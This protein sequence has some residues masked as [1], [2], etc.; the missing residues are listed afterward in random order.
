MNSKLDTTVVNKSVVS[1]FIYLFVMDLVRVPMESFNEYVAREPGYAEPMLKAF[2]NTFQAKP[3]GI[4]SHELLKKI[5]KTSTSHLPEAGRGEYKVCSNNFKIGPEFYTTGS[6][7]PLF[8]GTLLGLHELINT[9]IIN[10]KSHAISLRDIGD[11]TEGLKGW[12][13][14]P[15]SEGTAVWKEYCNG[16]LTAEQYI[17]KKH[18]PKLDEL[19]TDST[20]ETSIDPLVREDDTTV[21][22]K[23]IELM[24]WIIDDYEAEIV[25]CA[26]DDEKITSICKYIQRIEQLHPFAD[27]NVRTIYILLNK[28]LRDHGLTFSLLLNPNRFDA[29]DL[30]DLVR[31]VKE[32]QIIFKSLMENTNP[33]E[34]VVRTNERLGMLTTIRCPGVTLA[35]SGL[36]TQFIEEVLCK[37]KLAAPNH[38]FKTDKQGIFSMKAGSVLA[39]LIA[40]IKSVATENNKDILVALRKGQIGIAFRR[41]CIMH[42]TSSIGI[43]LKYKDKLNIDVNEPSS[44]TNTA[45]DWFDQTKVTTKAEKATREL[46]VEHGA[47]NRQ[48]L[49]FGTSS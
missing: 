47:K 24:Q 44:N 18:L 5:Q 45:L 26:T 17:P 46:L 35:C 21:H 32:G 27:G 4:I 34:F 9:W 6:I 3:D 43:F 22:A 7:G 40:E 19:F 13:I 29:C 36:V 25:L 16:N 39:T 12:G 23:T 42:L 48:E 11:T 8:S 38:T 28:L 49:S 33:D 15:N 14:L 20:V 31:M 1:R 37:H 2:I 10:K 41:S 30:V